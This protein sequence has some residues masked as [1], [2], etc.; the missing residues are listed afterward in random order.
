M[1]RLGS[2]SGNK[3]ML[4]V[5]IISLLD[6]NR[7]V[8][9]PAAM[10]KLNVADGSRVDMCVDP[11]EDGT[12]IVYVASVTE[13]SEGKSISKTG[14]LQD[15]MMYSWLIDGNDIK[16]RWKITDE[17]VDFAG[18]TWYKIVIF[19]TPTPVE[20]VTVSPEQAAMEHDAPGIPD[21]LDPIDKEETPQAETIDD[22]S[23]EEEVVPEDPRASHVDEPQ[24]EEPQ[25]EPA[26]EPQAVDDTE[27]F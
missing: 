10:S 2:T 5:P 24:G 6:N 15:E 8:L 7:L 22:S 25:E 26:E 3:E 19:D 20:E 1:I 4:L 27:N 18:A 16:V 23:P 9:G 13:R 11:Q 14:K 21:P 17:T 12:N